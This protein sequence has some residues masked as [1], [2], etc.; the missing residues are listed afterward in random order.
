MVQ[1]S[2]RIHADAVLQSGQQ[3]EEHVCQIAADGSRFQRSATLLATYAPKASKSA[4]LPIAYQLGA[5]LCN[6]SQGLA[7]EG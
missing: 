2:N 4:E 7:K 5:A 6:D 3:Q 1:W